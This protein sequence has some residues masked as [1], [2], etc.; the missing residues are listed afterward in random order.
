[1]LSLATP[2]QLAAAKRLR[3][4]IRAEARKWR[5]PLAAA[6]AGYAPARLHRPGN[7]AGLF[8]HAENR[9]FSNNNH[10]LDPSQPEVLIFAN[11]PGRPLVL[12][13][14]MFAV[15]RGVHGPTPGG[16]I[17]RWHTH[18]VCARG[19]KRGLKPR[20]DGSCPPGAKS[21]QGAE[22]LHFWLT[23]DLRSSYAIHGP[24]PELCAA[25][26][27]YHEACHHAGGH[28]H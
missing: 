23:R 18:R 8:L 7:A 19:L 3:K 10:Y 20:A 12:I 13:G 11:L 26:L 9:P 5:D 14:M 2:A 21:R 25:G 1:M 28:G 6:A 15:P 27:L 24:V 4:R 16:P 17:T 22:M